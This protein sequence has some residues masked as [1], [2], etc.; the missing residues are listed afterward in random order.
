MKGTG[1]IRFKMVGRGQIFLLVTVLEGV[2]LEDPFAKYVD[3]VSFF[4]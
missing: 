4:S 2:R 3:L 1:D